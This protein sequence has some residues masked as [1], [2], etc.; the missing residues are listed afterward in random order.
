MR[1]QISL[2]NRILFVSVF[3]LLSLGVTA[4]QFKKPLNSPRD[5]A[6]ASDAKFNVGIVGGADL[7][8]WLHFNSPS[9]SDWNLQNYTPHIFGSEGGSLGYFGGLAIEYMVNDYLSVSLNAIYAQHNVELGFV[10]DQFPYGWDPTSQSINYITKSK[11]FTAHYRT[12]EAY[13][14]ITYYMTLSSS[15]NIRPYVYVAPRVSYLLMLP[16][17]SVSQMK[18]NTTYSKDDNIITSS[19]DSVGFNTNT[20]RN[21]NLGATVGVGTQFRISTSN[22]Y[23]LVKFDVSANMNAL[24]TYTAADLQNEFNFLRYSADANA[25][26]TIQ[27]PIKKRLKGACVSWGEYE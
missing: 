2:F 7:T 13:V 15:K 10:D 27:L 14:P 1:H 24:S 19:I 26:L 25:S 6:Q 12:I 5:R 21:L 4:Q 17:D 18:L 23:F 20:Y 22:Y 16:N 11:T 3:T 9:A 8:T